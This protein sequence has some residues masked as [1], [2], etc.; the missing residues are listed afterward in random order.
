VSLLL[1]VMLSVVSSIII[2]DACFANRVT[3]LAENLPSDVTI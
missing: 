3:R 1:I 2:F